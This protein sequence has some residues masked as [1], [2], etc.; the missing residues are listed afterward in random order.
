MGRQE[1]RPR[2]GSFGDL[3]QLLLDDYQLQGHRSIESARNSLARLRAFFGDDRPI[4]EITYESLS[5]YAADRVSAGGARATARKELAALRRAFTLARRGD[6]TLVAPAWPTIRVRN[7]RQGFIEP[8]AFEC[9][10]RGLRPHLRGAV[11]LMYVTGWRRRT[12]TGL[13]WRNVDLE[14]GIIRLEPNTTKNDQ[15]VEFP[16][17][18]FPEL[19]AAL[20]EQLRYT[21]EYERRLHRVIPLVFHW[22][23]RHLKD[24]RDNWKSACAACGVAGAWLHDLRRSAVRNLE[25]ARVPRSV[26]MK[27]AGFRTENVY[28]RYAISA[29]EDQAAAVRLLARQHDDDLERAQQTCLP[30]R[31]PRVLDFDQHG[32]LPAGRVGPKRIQRQPTPM[33]RSRPAE[34]PDAWRGGRARS[35]AQDC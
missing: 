31:S 2:V 3:A 35:K 7:A 29:R 6:P 15:G 34:S 1:G 26:A 18:D 30:L 25:R 13:L 9:I 28:T 32:G 23:G 24:F 20:E 22:R 33:E 16:F 10:R 8:A 17:A 11:T 5:R 21:R 4:D 12:V 19:V 14:G 27:L